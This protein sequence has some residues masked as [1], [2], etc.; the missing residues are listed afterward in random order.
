MSPSAAKGI[1]VRTILSV[2]FARSDDLSL[3]CWKNRAQ[4]SDVPPTSRLARA[5]LYYCRRRRCCWG[6]HEAAALHAPAMRKSRRSQR[7]SSALLLWQCSWGAAMQAELMRL[8]RSDS[9]ELMQFKTGKH[10]L[11]MQ[12]PCFAIDLPQAKRVG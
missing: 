3:P 6:A 10:D 11:V 7:L 8:L 12:T 2:P 1:N 5:G 9:L 4:P